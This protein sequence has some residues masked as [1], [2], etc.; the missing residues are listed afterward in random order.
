MG[1]E[2]NNPSVFKIRIIP[3]FFYLGFVPAHHLSALRL[4]HS[5][6]HLFPFIIMGKGWV[7][8]PEQEAYLEGEFQNYLKARKDG[9]VK[10][11][12]AILH[13][14]WEE[15]WPERQVLINEWNLSDDTTFNTTQMEA[16]GEALAARKTVNALIYH[17][18]TFI[19]CF[20]SSNFTTTFVGTQMQNQCAQKTHKAYSPATSTS[21]QRKAPRNLSGS[22]RF[23]KSTVIDTTNQNFKAWLTR[24]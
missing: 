19:Q 4:T 8:T 10:N 2:I 22:I 17:N 21:L 3:F 12:R 7:R 9:E 14:K 20:F 24:S 6:L 15:R 16:L 11:W 13:D 23:S 5:S 1:T 18:A